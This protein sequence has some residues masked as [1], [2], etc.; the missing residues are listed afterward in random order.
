[1][2]EK[3]FNE[4]VDKVGVK[5]AE[6]IKAKMEEAQKALDLKLEN[7]AKNNASKD[8]VKA[9]KA[10][11]A[12]ELNDSILAAVKTEY[13]KI[14]KAQGEAIGELKDQ[15]KAKNNS[16]EKLSFEAKIFKAFENMS[17]EDKANW[18]TMIATNKQSSPFFI[19]VDKAA[20]TMG[21]DNTI[22]AGATQ[23]S[24][25]ENTGIISAIRQR[26][27]K[28]LSKVS[29][30]SIT[31][32][33][34]LW[35]EETDQQGNPIFIGEGDA[36]IQLSSLW[37]ERTEPVK[38]IAVFAKVTT[39]LLADLPQ[40]VSYIKNSLMKRLSIKT[41]DQLLS[42]DGLNDNLKG[43]E[44][45]ATAFSAGALALAVEGANEF[46][47]LTAIA[48]QVKVANGIPNGVFVNPSTWAKMQTLKDST[49]RPIWKDY[50]TPAGTVV[51]AGMEIIETTGV[52]DGEFI[53]GDLSVLN[54]LFREQITIQVG[55]DGN[56]FTN[57]KKTIL[58][59]SRL[60]Q[61][62]SA[63]DTPCLVKGDFVTAKGLLETV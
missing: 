56:D 61:F 28:Y 17:D 2:D 9:I 8:E 32:A 46:D 50:V 4:L 55:L 11:I 58:V 47:V 34:A 59:E 1:M 60:V 30:G 26:I 23:V 13:D 7:A 45:L 48:L 21:E 35:V 15:L 57:N 25:T 63:N 33:R 51:F 43:A 62:A 49:G 27:E 41:E 40:L 5:A 12:K 36:K 14:L 3:Q 16:G 10:E 31:N 29:T 6:I 42:G 22:G 24:L 37:I 19:T 52:T 44:T 18:K 20:V 38:K 53:G 54:V 39:E